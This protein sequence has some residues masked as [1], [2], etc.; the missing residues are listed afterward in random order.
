MNTAFLGISI[1]DNIKYI[2]EYSEV[3]TSSV[4]VTINWNNIVYKNTNN[5]YICQIWI[6]EFVMIGLIYKYIYI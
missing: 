3:V 1:R 6:K 2:E 5:I 4:Y